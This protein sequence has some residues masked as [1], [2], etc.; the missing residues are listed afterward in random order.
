ML[1]IADSVIVSIE[2][3]N[4]I[5]KLSHISEF[6]KLIRYEINVQTLIAILNTEIKERNM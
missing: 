1:L 5:N 6:K 2:K 4:R 3:S